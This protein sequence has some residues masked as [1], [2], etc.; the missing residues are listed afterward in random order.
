MTSHFATLL[1]HGIVINVNS[2]LGGN[3]L[4]N[5]RLQARMQGGGGCVWGV[6]P[7]PLVFLC[8]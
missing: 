6:K 3:I 8:V 1:L 7:P 2:S 5:R 4:N